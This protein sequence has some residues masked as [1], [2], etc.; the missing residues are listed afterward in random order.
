MGKGADPA[1]RGGVYRARCERGP[2][3]R[4]GVY[5]PRQDK[6]ITWRAGKG[7]VQKFLFRCSCRGRSPDEREG[8]FGAREV[9]VRGEVP[10]RRTR[11]RSDKDT[12]SPVDRGMRN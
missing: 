5:S 8:E 11:S 7:P 10:L 4:G 9:T 6:K 3:K 2:A 12:S 1:K